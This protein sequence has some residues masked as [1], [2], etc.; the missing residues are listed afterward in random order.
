[1]KRTSLMHE[2]TN[3]QTAYHGCTFRQYYFHPKDPNYDYYIYTENVKITVKFRKHITTWG[4]LTR[5]ACRLETPELHILELFSLLLF[6]NRTECLIYKVV[7]IDRDKLWLVYTQISPGHIWITLY[8]YRVKELTLI[9]R[10][11]Q[12]VKTWNMFIRVK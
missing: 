12:K 1:M 6:A 4:N 5:V 7:Q 3:Y 8:I 2:Y 9:T 10:W 11:L